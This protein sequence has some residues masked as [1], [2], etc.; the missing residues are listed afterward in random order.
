[1]HGRRRTG[2]FDEEGRWEVTQQNPRLAEL[3]VWSGLTLA[4]ALAL[5]LAWVGLIWFWP[6]LGLPLD[7]PDG[8][9][10]WWIRWDGWIWLA[11]E[12]D[13]ELQ[14]GESATIGPSYRELQCSAA[15]VIAWK[16]PNTS[17]TSLPAM[18]AKVDDLTS[19]EVSGL[20]RLT[21]NLTWRRLTL[22]SKSGNNGHPG[23]S[24]KSRYLN[25]YE[26]FLELLLGKEKDTNTGDYDSIVDRFQASGKLALNA[27]GTGPGLTGQQSAGKGSSGASSIGRVSSG[28]GEASSHRLRSAAPGES[29]RS[30]AN[31]ESGA[32]AQAF[33]DFVGADST[34]QVEDSSYY[35]HYQHQQ[36]QNQTS[37][38]G[39][40]VAQQ[41]ELDGA[42]VVS[43]LDG[44]SHEL[45]AVLVG[46]EDPEAEDDGLTPEAAAKL[47]EALFPAISATSGPRWDDL[48]N[49][50]PDFLTQPGAGAEME[51]QLHFGTVDAA[52]AR[53]SWLQQWGNVLTGY[54]DHVWGD[55]EP[56]AAEARREVEQLKTRDPEVPGPPPETKALDRL[57]QILAHVRGF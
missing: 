45:D 20:R 54:T 11:E 26:T 17:A 29:L 34:L 48:L 2:F 19:K 39:A 31:L 55:L 25:T 14:L 22:L 35:P 43:L 21:P 13:G 47:R 8:D 16:P 49:L 52:Q 32:S 37:S 36:G 12:P 44:P 50:N 42:A 53:S 57:R 33:N 1:M 15:T 23:S 51:M 40:A 24:Q 56:L 18:D 7:G 41:E 5:A 27:F 6:G 4:L 46:A 30:Q 28:A 9:R 38:K 10:R 3:Q